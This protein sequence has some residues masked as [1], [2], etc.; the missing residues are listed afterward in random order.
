MAIKSTIFKLDLNIADNSRGYYEDHSLTLA[1][2]PSETNQRMILRI[3]V[4]ALNAHEHLQFTKGLSDADEPDMWQKDLTGEIKHWIEL[5]QPHEK[6]IRQACGKSS[7]VSIYTYQRGAAQ[8]WFEGMKDSLERFK[9]L[10]VIHLT[11]TD[12]SACERLV[13]RSMQ[14][15]CLID[16]QQILLSSDKDSVTIE[17]TV[18]KDVLR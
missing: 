6:R 16:D 2:H 14:L 17:M 11:G 1:K 15:S 7:S 4:F 5:G 3:A 9:H 12:D 8:N 13:D 10:R 18:L